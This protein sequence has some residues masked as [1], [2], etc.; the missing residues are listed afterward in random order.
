[1]G[2]GA[3]VSMV[4]ACAQGWESPRI[5]VFVLEV[6][7]IVSVIASGPPLLMAYLIWRWVVHRVRDRVSE[8]MAV[9]FGAVLGSLAPLAM[10]AAVAGIASPVPVALAGI[11]AASTA[12]G[13]SAWILTA[14]VPRRTVS[15]P[16]SPKGWRATFEP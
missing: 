14:R 6:A 4:I 7:L 13:L 12:V 1:M 16:P 10:F 2:A 8:V 11:I 9:T 3:L 15:S 5:L